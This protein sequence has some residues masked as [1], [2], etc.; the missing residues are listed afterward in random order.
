[1]KDGTLLRLLT[2]V[3]VLVIGDHLSTY[4]C[5]VT[6]NLTMTGS[7]TNPFSQWLFINIGLAP[8]LILQT[9]V[10]AILFYVIYRMY[11]YNPNYPNRQRLLNL[12]L[13]VMLVVLII[14]NINNW[15]ILYRLYN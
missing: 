10:K 11:I 5:L 15:Y 2:L 6:P 13:W 14:T 8:A 7:E 12:S 9:T 3:F 4:L 1:M